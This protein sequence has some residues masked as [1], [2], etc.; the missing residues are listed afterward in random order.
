MLKFK[1]NEHY[2]IQFGWL[3]T[4]L[5]IDKVEDYILKRKSL[6]YNILLHAH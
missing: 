1:Y 2:Q 5:W 6:F 4:K 3:A